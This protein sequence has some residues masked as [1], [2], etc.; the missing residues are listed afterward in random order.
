M[1]PFQVCT[2]QDHYKYY[3]FKT[4]EMLHLKMHHE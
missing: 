4:I 2:T 3:C 1:T